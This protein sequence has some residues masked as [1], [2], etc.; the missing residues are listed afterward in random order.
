MKV[1][2]IQIHWDYLGGNMAS[3]AEIRQKYPQYANRSD[4]ELA[5]AFHTK[6]YSKLPKEEF[7]SKIGFSPNQEPELLQKPD[8]EKKGWHGVGSDL[9]DKGL[10]SL[11]EI[12]NAVLNAPAEIGGAAHQIFGNNQDLSGT[13]QEQ[14]QQAMKNGIINQ[15]QKRAGKNLLAG[16]GNLGHEILSAP[17]NLRDYLV[18]KA[19]ASPESPSMRLPEWLLPKDY[20]YAKALGIEGNQAGDKLLQGIPATAAS[21][22]IAKLAS[23]LLAELPITQKLASRPLRKAE[24]GAMERGIA[25]IPIESELLAKAKTRLPDTPEVNMLLEDAAKGDY[26]A[27]FSLQSD[28]KAES[29]NL[30]KSPMAAERRQSKEVYSLGKQVVDSIKKQLEKEG[31]NDLSKLLSKGQNKYRQYKKLDEKVYPLLKKAGLPI[32]MAALFGWGYHNI[33]HESHD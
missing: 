27:L 28:L 19:I 13:S 24:A 17:G 11:L 16:F 14:I 5:D 8:F 31:H 3:L 9:L 25:N 20:D 10:N 2:K 6:Y 33:G 7:Y 12:P 30:A 26:K 22:G 21:A 29:R 32:G 1:M 15:N 23:P 4:Q 18:K